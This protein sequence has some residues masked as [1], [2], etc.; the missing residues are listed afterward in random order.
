MSHPGCLPVWSWRKTRWG[1]TQPEWKRSDLAPMVLDIMIQKWQSVWVQFLN[2]IQS[3]QCT[4]LQ[5]AVGHIFL[6]NILHGNIGFC[7][8]KAVWKISITIHWVSNK[9][10]SFNYTPVQHLQFGSYRSAYVACLI[11]CPQEIFHIF[12]K[13]LK[14]DIFQPSIICVKFSVAAVRN[15]LP[16]NST[17]LP[18]QCC[19]TPWHCCHQIHPHVLCILVTEK[20]GCCWSLATAQ[21]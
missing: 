17:A 11:M 2:A 14:G 19:Y 15:N 21:L 18:Q 9:F 10:L 7:I 6:L 16:L 13:G 12:E 4:G 3:L 5:C 8:C 1:G 20:I